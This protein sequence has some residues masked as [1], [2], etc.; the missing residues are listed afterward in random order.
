[1]YAV[2]VSEGDEVEQ[3]ASELLLDAGLKR[4]FLAC[5]IS[6]GGFFEVDPA[7][8]VRRRSSLNH[9]PVKKVLK[10][11]VRSQVQQGLFA[12][13]YIAVPQK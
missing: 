6:L 4:D 3:V 2:F 9:E 7:A 13:I 11:K 5:L 1:M 8:E 10:L 12:L